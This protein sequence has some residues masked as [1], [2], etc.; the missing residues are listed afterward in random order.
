M[1]DRAETFDNLYRADP[2]PWTFT[3]SDYERRKY[4]ATLAALPRQTY[5]HALEV[6]CSIGVLTASLATRCDAVTGLDVSPVALELA[7]ARCRGH[8]V[9]LVRAEIPREWPEGRF[10]LIVFSE[11]LYFLTAEE[12]AASAVCALAA[13][14]PGGDIL[15]VNWL[16]PCD[17]GLTGEEAVTVFAIAIEAGGGHCR[18]LLRTEQYRIDLAGSA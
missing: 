5:A 7:A 6:G 3:T 2:D 11:V 14:E 9:R 1:T 4:E 18:T 13:L 8:A 15:L 10:D 17:T 12:V 16:G